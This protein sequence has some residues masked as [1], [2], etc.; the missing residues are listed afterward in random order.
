LLEKLRK[1]SF[2]INDQKYLFLNSKLLE[3]VYNMHEEEGRQKEEE[4]K[5]LTQTVFSQEQEIERLKKELENAQLN[6]AAKE[7]KEK[8]LAVVTEEIEPP[9]SAQRVHT[10]SQQTKRTPTLTLKDLKEP[11][12]TVNSNSIASKLQKTGLHKAK[13]KLK[14]GF[15][16]PEDMGKLNTGRGLRKG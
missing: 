2:E 15:K 10:E 7:R 8:I 11:L 13:E 16:R 9:L 12:Q 5:K 6:A 3:Q 14:E 1:Y 4:H